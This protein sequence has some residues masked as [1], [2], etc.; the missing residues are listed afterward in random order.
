MIVSATLDVGPGHWVNYFYDTVS[1]EHT[2]EVWQPP[3][4]AQRRKGSRGF[5][6]NTLIPYRG[7]AEIAELIDWLGR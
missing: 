2:V 1:D 3:L 6:L 7:H 4:R 5:V